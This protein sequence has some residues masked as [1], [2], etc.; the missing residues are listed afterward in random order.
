M[1]IR[2]FGQY[3]S[4]LALI[5]ITVVGTG[6]VT[7]GRRVLLKEYG[8]SV[9]ALAEGTLKGSTICLKGFSCAPNLTNLE[10]KSKPDE[11]SP[12][13][14]VDLTREQDKLWDMEMKALRDRKSVV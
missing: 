4:L 10:L 14:Y 8:P 5:A 3:L 9:P 11:P 6:C 7:N 2:G 1:W 13:K 12:F